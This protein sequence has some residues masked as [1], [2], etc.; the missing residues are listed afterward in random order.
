MSS[1]FTR[2]AVVFSS[3]ALVPAALCCL[4]DMQSYSA[5]SPQTSKGKLNDMAN[6]VIATFPEKPTYL[7][8]QSLTVRTVIDNRGADET[9]VPSRMSPSQFTYFLRSQREG[10]PVY[11]LSES[12]T[13]SRRSPDRIG[14]E[15]TESE[16]IPSGAKFEREEDI[17]DF[18]NEGFDPGKYWLTVRYGDDGPES[19]RSAVSIL[20]L[21]VESFSSAVSEDHLS[22]VVA[23]RRADG[24]TV[25]LQRESYVL[26]P[27]EGVFRLRQM[28]AKGGPVG[29]ATAIDVAPAGNGRWFCWTQDGMLNASVGW[30]NRLIVSAQPVPAEGRLLSPGFQVALGTGLFGVVSPTG[31]LTTYLASASGLKPHWNADLPGARGKVEWNAQPDGSV[32]AAW[33][34]AGSGRILR[35]SFSADGHPADVTPGS[36]TPARPVAWGLPVTGPPVVWVLNP[37]KDGFSLTLMPRSGERSV[38]HLPALGKATSWDFYVSA[39]GTSTGAVVSNGKIFFTP[40]SS[41]AWKEVSD[42]PGALGLHIVSLN[43]RS[44]WAEWIEPGFGFRRISIR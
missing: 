38:T 26:D 40:L 11:G 9:Q 12:I 8:G 36:L 34:E 39:Q 13:S 29:V 21:D 30:G 6:V 2:G 15:P 22:T 3:A 20:P 16:P 17:A 7:S 4:L 32:T 14:A 42:A 44:F 23:H 35:Q 18:W 5:P 31:R 27:R 24:Q 25:L 43:G 10:G 19:P 37:D 33:E 41:P 28:L 1:A